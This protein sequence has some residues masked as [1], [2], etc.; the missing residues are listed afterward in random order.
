MGNWCVVWLMYE[1]DEDDDED[2][3]EDGGTTTTADEE[4]LLLPCCCGI[5]VGL[6]FPDGSILACEL[7]L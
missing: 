6:L 1:V 7:R 2:D 4:L 5:P 3:E